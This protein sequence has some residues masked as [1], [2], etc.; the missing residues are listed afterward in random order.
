MYASKNNPLAKLSDVELTDEIINGFP[1]AYA[2]MK[3]QERINGH[4][5]NMNLKATAYNYESRMALLLSSRFIGYLPEH[6]AK[7]YVDSGELIAI[8][9]SRRYYHLE[10][11]AI[12]KKRP[13]HSIK[14]ARCLLK[15]CE[16]TIAKK[17][18]VNSSQRDYRATKKA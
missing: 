3:T 5:A 8:A 15:P 13:M 16:T 12:T 17:R 1:V 18:A 7:P 10:I 11:M 2:G 6:Y 14:F 4:L 9:P